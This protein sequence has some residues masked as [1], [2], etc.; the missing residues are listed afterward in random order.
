MPLP[1]AR[2]RHHVVMSSDPRPPSPWAP[3]PPSRQEVEDKFE[4]LL[5]GS[6]TRDEVDRWAAQWV[7][8]VDAGIEDDAVWW[9]LSKLAGIDLRHGEGMPYLH[10]ED[11]I[12][13]WLD[14]FKGRCEPER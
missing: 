6:A 12:A 3:R 8:A 5:N 4:A 11:Q 2:E 13:E 10:D 7:A 9:G 14:D 1:G